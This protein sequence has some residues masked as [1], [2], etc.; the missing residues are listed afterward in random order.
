MNKLIF[1]FFYGSFELLLLYL[2]TILIIGCSEITGK[3]AE[4]MQNEISESPEIYFCPGD[5]CGKALE[6]RIRAANFS[7]HC[8]FYDMDLAKVADALSGKASAV[9]VKL[10]FDR[11]N[12]DE[13]LKLRN[14]RLDD[15]KQLMH[16]KFCVLDG[17]AVVTGSFNPTDND[18]N[19][20]N[21]NMLVIS[22]KTLAKNYE[23]EF[24][25]MRSG[26]FGGGSNVKNPVF[27][28]NGMM[29]ENYFCPE[30]DCASHI[31]GLIKS[32]ESSVYFMSF[33]FTNEAIADSLV[34]KKGMDIRGIFDSS[35]ASNKFSQFKRMKG[36]GLNVKL[37]SNK[38]KLHHKVFIID[39]NTVVTGSFNPT[40]SADT[41]NDEN[42]IIIHDEKIAGLFLD[43]FDS[44]WNG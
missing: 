19:Y 10:V 39:N 33:S 3:A 35:Q 24:D 43:E 26:K 36:F 44:L 20:N 15:N 17:N 16:N 42:V 9:D 6:S 1:K 38:Y 21:N 11:S 31:I 12:Y 30:D 7:V 4:E 32:S 40:L 18:N 23:E 25:E 14:V 5:D 22:S 29:V 2:V 27:Y 41:K 28:L 37:D 8:A 13:K 34:R